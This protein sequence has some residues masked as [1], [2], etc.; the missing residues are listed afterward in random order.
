MQ[1]RPFTR[2]VRV[3]IGLWLVLGITGAGAH[4]DDWYR[5]RGLASYYGKGFHGR[6][7]ADGNAFLKMR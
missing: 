6:K 3:G 2:Q 1:M 4:A 7:A 5:E